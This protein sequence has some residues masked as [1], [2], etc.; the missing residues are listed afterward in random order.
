MKG[1]SSIT[2]HRRFGCMIVVCAQCY[3]SIGLGSFFTRP[4]PFDVYPDILNSIP[5][6]YLNET[7]ST[8]IPSPTRGRP[9]RHARPTDYLNRNP[10][11][12]D[13]LLLLAFVRSPSAQSSWRSRLVW[14]SRSVS[15]PRYRR[16]LRRHRAAH[17]KPS[18]SCESRGA[19]RSR[20]VGKVSCGVADAPFPGTFFMTGSG[21]CVRS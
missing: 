15:E 6:A 1:C 11:D 16:S 3:K 14:K 7:L 20:L 8:T 10:R 19:I 17:S 12:T 4:P 21:G 13:L 5:P 2:L 9:T 18:R